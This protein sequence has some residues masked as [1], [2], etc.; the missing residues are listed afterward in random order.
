MPRS[1]TAQIRPAV[2]IFTVA[3]PGRI[4]PEAKTS[5]T[6]SVAPAMTLVWVL[7][8]A[9]AAASGRKELTT[10]VGE[11]SPGSADTGKPARAHS[12]CDQVPFGTFNSMLPI[13]SIVSVTKSPVSR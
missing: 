12:S 1:V 2:A 7:S 10:C 3:W 4:A 9:A 11:T 5:I 6:V 13:A 8:P